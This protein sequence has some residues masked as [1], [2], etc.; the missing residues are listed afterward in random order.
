MN[1]KTQ[2]NVIQET[3]M[4][5]AD[6]V[7]QHT[8]ALQAQRPMSFEDIHNNPNELAENHVRLTEEARIQQNQAS[9]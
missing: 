3:R 4:T 5:W 2:G 7:E 6:E 8:E 9:W 1:T